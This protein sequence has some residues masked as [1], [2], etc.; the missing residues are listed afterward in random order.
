MARTTHGPTAYAD[1]WRH[2]LIQAVYQ[3]IA[4]HGLKKLR[5]HE[6]A[7]QMRLDH[8]TLHYYFPT[9][10]AL[11]EAVAEYTIFQKLLVNVPHDH[12]KGSPTTRLHEF[13]EDGVLSNRFN[14]RDFRWKV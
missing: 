10:V 2:A 3:S 13:L 8:S 12:Q 7:T 5:T 6:V 1:E 11:I 9:K 4:Q 14:Q